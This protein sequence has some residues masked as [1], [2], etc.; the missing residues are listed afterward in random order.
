MYDFFELWLG[1]LMYYITKVTHYLC[2]AMF[3]NIIFQLIKGV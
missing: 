1:T 3:L 2:V